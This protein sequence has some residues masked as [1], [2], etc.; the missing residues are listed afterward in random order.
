MTPGSGIHYQPF[1]HATT[2]PVILPDMPAAVLNPVSAACSIIINHLLAPGPPITII[3]RVSSASFAA[4][5]SAASSRSFTRA[6]LCF[7]R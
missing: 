2:A 5:M 4:A 1:T 6:T 7:G 3:P